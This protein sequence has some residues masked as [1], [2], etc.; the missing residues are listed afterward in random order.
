MNEIITICLYATDEDFFRYLALKAAEQ[1]IQ[2][3]KNII[4]GQATEI[5][6]KYA[7]KQAK[8]LNLW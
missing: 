1:S 3:Q 6:K 8:P 7:P 5:A 4:S 2:N